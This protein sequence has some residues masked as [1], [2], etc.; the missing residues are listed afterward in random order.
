MKLQHLFLLVALVLF[1][2]GSNKNLKDRANVVEE[3]SRRVL[4]NHNKNAFDATFLSAEL[5]IH[6]EKGKTKQN[7]VV[8]LRVQNDSTI[9]LS[10]SFFG[11]PV[12]KAIITPNRVSY[13]VK[14]NKTYFDGDFSTLSKLLGTELNYNMVQNLL[15]GDA[16]LDLNSSDYTSTIDKQ[17]HLLSPKNDMDVANILYW[18]NP[19]NYKVERQEIKHSTAKKFLS[20]NYPS[21]LQVDETYIPKKLEILANSNTQRAKIGIEYKSVKLEKSLSFPYSI[22]KGYKKIKK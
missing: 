4:K 12:A 1:S 8:K 5:K 7:L 17:A 15:M 13:Y 9:W 19:L 11:F 20:I 10:G 21:Y 2:C 14:I 18:F 3:S 6:F 22:P 16:I